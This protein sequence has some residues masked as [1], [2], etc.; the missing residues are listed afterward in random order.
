MWP[1]PLGASRWATKRRGQVVAE[2]LSRMEGGG[3]QELSSCIWFDME[4]PTCLHFL[5]WIFF[6]FWNILFKHFWRRSIQQRPGQWAPAR[7]VCCSAHWDEM[8][9]S[10]DWGCSYF[11]PWWPGARSVLD[12]KLRNMDHNENYLH[13]IHMRWFMY[14]FMHRSWQSRVF[15]GWGV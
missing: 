12:K 10:W 2:H 6:K 8:W 3:S 4:C 14:F 5:Q 15:L 11:L 9:L 7:P 13:M 1:C